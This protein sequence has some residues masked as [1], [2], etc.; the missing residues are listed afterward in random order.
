MKLE[1]FS[2]VLSYIG[3]TMILTAFILETRNFV[4]SKDK[5]YL[6][7]MAIG[8]GLL[9]IRALLI[10]EWAFLVLEVIWC[11]AAILAI[12]KYQR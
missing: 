8:S 4:K 7:L 12:I 11:I 9:A 5:I 1:L 2:E 10:H 6:S 3:M